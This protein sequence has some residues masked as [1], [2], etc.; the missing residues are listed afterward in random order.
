MRI[1]YIED[2]VDA[3]TIFSR[4]LKADQMKL[5]TQFFQSNHEGDIVDTIHRVFENKIHGVIINPGALTHTSVA[6]RDALLLLSCPI[7]EIHLSNIYKREEFRHT[8]MIAGVAAG[9]ISGFG[10]NSYLLGLRVAVD[11]LSEEG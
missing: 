11:I 6:L 1:G 4:K 3:R 10:V 9:Q 2:D 8:S 5:D 7:V